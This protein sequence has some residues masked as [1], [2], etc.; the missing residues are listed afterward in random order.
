MLE[1]GPNP[2]STEHG[3]YLLDMSSNALCFQDGCLYTDVVWYAKIR[4]KLAKQQTENGMSAVMLTGQSD[5]VFKLP[6]VEVIMILGIQD[7]DP[8]THQPGCPD[9]G[10]FIAPRP[11]CVHDGWRDIFHLI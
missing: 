2:L 9:R 4:M 8:F 10:S 11:A 6:L 5:V 3:R 1:V 7:R